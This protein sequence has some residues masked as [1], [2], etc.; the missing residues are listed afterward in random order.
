MHTHTHTHTV[1]H[2]TNK[3]QNLKNV[4]LWT[5]TSHYITHAFG[6]YTITHLQHFEISNTATAVV[7]CKTKTKKPHLTAQNLSLPAVACCHNDVYVHRSMYVQPQNT[8]FPANHSDYYLTHSMLLNFWTARL[9]HTLFSANWAKALKQ[10]L[11]LWSMT[12][13]AIT[14]RS[15]LWT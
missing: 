14:F 4:C 3:T 9:A 12:K 2:T 10:T 6:I 11:A 13:W 5:W 7:S 8:Q 15:K 1:T